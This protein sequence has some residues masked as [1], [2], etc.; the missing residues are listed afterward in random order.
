MGDEALQVMWQDLHVQS[1][2]DMLDRFSALAIKQRITNCIVVSMHGMDVDVRSGGTINTIHKTI[3]Y[4]DLARD[5]LLRMLR[6][7]V[8][9]Q[10]NNGDEL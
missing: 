1:V 4:L 8:E 9:R 3:A 5:E 10:G 7:D 2:T 6:R